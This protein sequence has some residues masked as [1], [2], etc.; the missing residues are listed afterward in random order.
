MYCIAK[1]DQQSSPRHLYTAA[2]PF[3][4]DLKAWWAGKASPEMR[5]K[6]ENYLGELREREMWLACDCRGPDEHPALFSVAKKPTGGFTIRSMTKRALHADGCLHA[7]EPKDCSQEP[8]SPPRLP[9]EKP[10]KPPSF[11]ET[12]QPASRGTPLAPFEIV[13]NAKAGPSVPLP[14]IAR[15]LYW[16]A[17]ESGLQT[18]ESRCQPHPVKALRTY[19]NQLPTG[20]KG[21]VLGDLLY[22]TPQAWYDAWMDKS[23]DT[24]LKAG[25]QAQAILVCPVSAV[26]GQHRDIVLQQGGGRIHVSGRIA[27]YGGMDLEARFPMLMIARIIKRGDSVEASRAYLHPILSEKRW[28]LVDSDYERKA[29]E[30]IEQTC[31]QLERR[32]GIAWSV[33][34]PLFNWESTGARPDFVIRASLSGRSVSIVVETMGSDDPEYAA[35]KAETVARLTHHIVFEDKR[36]LGHE[37]ANER[38]R[39]YLFGRVAGELA[40]I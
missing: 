30:V 3:E 28:L 4:L 38:L 5:A 7:F 2:L 6:V 22:C 18:Q 9:N 27:V 31:L 13:G 40:N 39:R 24:C 21:V 11:I 16:L 15:Q 25:L 34:K 23:F 33:E 12:E 8:P 29:F 32:Y 20:T 14:P 19:A 37:M 36:Y 35:R 26:E 10:T 1:H 17:T